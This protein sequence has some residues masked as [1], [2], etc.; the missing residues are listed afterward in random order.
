MDIISPEL[1]E[2]LVC[3]ETHQS[4][5]LAPAELVRRLA[6]L[7]TEGKLK[8]RAGA[9]PAEPIQGALVRADGAVAYPICDGIPIM[10]VDEGI[11]L[12]RK[13]E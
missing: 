7:Q 5:S 3:P 13:D 12:E 4:L 11:P 8:N 10:L 2:I 6:A 1:L 9:V